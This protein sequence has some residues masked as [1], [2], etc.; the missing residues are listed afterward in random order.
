[1]DAPQAPQPAP[2]NPATPNP[3]TDRAVLEFLAWRYD[4]LHTL[5]QFAVAGLIILSLAV[6]VFLFKQMR[7]VRAQLPAQRDAVIRY[8]M[9]FQKR[10]D[11]TIRSF[12]GKLQQFAAANPDFRPVLDAY[13]THLSPYFLAVPQ[14]AVQKPVPAVGP[15]STNKR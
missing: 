8:A 9:E 13:R 11:G 12:V 14:P 3:P 1:M 10:D 15:A 7:L 2:E 5:F 4:R 6:N